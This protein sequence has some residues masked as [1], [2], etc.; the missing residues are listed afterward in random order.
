MRGELKVFLHH[1]GSSLL[2]ELETLVVEQGGKRRDYGIVKVRST[3]KNAILSLAGIESMEQAD[4]LKG[5]KLLVQRGRLPEPAA[6]EYYVHDL[7]GMEAFDNGVRLGVVTGSRPQGDIEIAIVTG[8]SEE[9]E[10]PLV[11][12]FLVEM[13]FV[14][15]KLE[16]QQTEDLPRNPLRPP[17]RAASNRN[18]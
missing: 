16:L 14:G 4:E 7:L 10:V 5:G 15:R 1:S 2:S 3:P 8:D 18:Q 6:D 11:D 13:D 9:L 12:V 17:R